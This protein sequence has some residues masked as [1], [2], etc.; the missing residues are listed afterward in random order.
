LR[1]F[2]VE[3]RASISERSRT[4]GSFFFLLEISDL[5][6]HPFPFQ[7]SPVQKLKSGDIVPGC[8]LGKLPFIHEVEQL[9]F[10]VVFP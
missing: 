7:G 4:T 9:L 5:L 6:H 1:F 10:E 2:V 8:P 3:R